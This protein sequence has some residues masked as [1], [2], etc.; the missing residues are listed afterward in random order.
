M[1][2]KPLGFIIQHQPQ[3]SYDHERDVSLHNVTRNLSHTA[4]PM[5]SESLTQTDNNFH[6]TENKTGT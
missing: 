1:G 4:E 2:W 6:S 5:I 3:W